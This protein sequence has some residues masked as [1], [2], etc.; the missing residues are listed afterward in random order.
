MTL[1]SE[2]EIGQVVPERIP[3]LQESL[4]ESVGRGN[5]EPPEPTN[6]DR[7]RTSQVLLARLIRLHMAG[8]S[9]EEIVEQVL[10]TEPENLL[11][12]A[13]IMVEIILRHAGCSAKERTL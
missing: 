10:T 7:A 6:R 1:T 11:F 5:G 2:Q 12:R 13:T 8:C 3:R 4:G 9:P